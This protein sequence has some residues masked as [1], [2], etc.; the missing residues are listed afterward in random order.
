MIQW[1][2]AETLKQLAGLTF[3][4]NIAAKALTDKIVAVLDKHAPVRTIQVRKNFAPW[5]NK[6]LKNKMIERDTAREIAE[7]S[8]DQDDWRSFRNT[9]NT[10][11]NLMKLVKNEWNKKK[12]DSIAQTSSNVWKNL[13]RLAGFKQSGGPPTQLH[14]MGRMVTSPV[15][16]SSVMNSFFVTKIKDLL[17]RL[18]PQ[19]E[20]PLENLRRMMKNRQC[21]FSIKAVQPDE[22]LKIVKS[23]RNSMKRKTVHRITSSN[24]KAWLGY[25]IIMK[26]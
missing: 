16:L 13:K 6:D 5:M 23:L 7:I 19:K 4:A 1:P 14:Y 22:V 24:R 10:V 21:T 9:R 11:N 2:F 3:D 25:G 12:L 26:F 8:G 15:E 20:D 17:K 18:P